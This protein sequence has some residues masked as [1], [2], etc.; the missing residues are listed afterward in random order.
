MLTK[1]PMF[2]SKVT[3]KIQTV[4]QTAPSELISQ[5]RIWLIGDR[6]SH[7][8]REF[9]HMCS[10]KKEKKNPQ[11]PQLHNV[12]VLLSQWRTHG[13]KLMLQQCHQPHPKCWGLRVCCTVLTHLHWHPPPQSLGSSRICSRP[14]ERTSSLPPTHHHQNTWPEADDGERCWEER[15]TWLISFFFPSTIP[16]KLRTLSSAAQI[17]NSRFLCGSSL[18]F[19]S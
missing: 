17:W 14:A 5:L 8:W 18:F 3:L 6:F 11:N 13:F 1:I 7:N 12:S 2:V 9:S 19:S 10:M 4:F 15:N 16:Q